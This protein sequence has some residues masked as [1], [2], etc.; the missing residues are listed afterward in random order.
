MT[1]KFIYRI[2]TCAHKRCCCTTMYPETLTYQNRVFKKIAIGTMGYDWKIC[3]WNFF[4]EFTYGC[5]VTYQF[6]LYNY[7]NKQTL[8]YACTVHIKF[9]QRGIQNWLTEKGLFQEFSITSYWQIY[10]QIF[11]LNLLYSSPREISKHGG[12]S[13][14]D[15]VYLGWS[16]APSHEPKCGGGGGCAASANE[17]SCNGAQI[18]FTGPI[19]YLIHVSTVNTSSTLLLTRRPIL[20]DL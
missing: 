14:R 4:L 17:Y 6:T 18:N 10:W 15:V 20:H 9:K 12:G 19:P 8:R 5:W 7:A 11:W 3:S 16:I 13:Q 2:K 1:N